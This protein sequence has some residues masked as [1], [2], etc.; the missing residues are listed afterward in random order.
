MCAVL[1]GISLPLALPGSFI[2]SWPSLASDFP[3]LLLCYAVFLCYAVS[4]SAV[5]RGISFPP[6][7]SGSFF[8]SWPSLASDSTSSVSMLLLLFNFALC[9]PLLRVFFCLFVCAAS[10]SRVSISHGSF[11]PPYFPDGLVLLV[12]ELMALCYP[13]SLSLSFFFA[14]YS[15]FA[16]ALLSSFDFWRTCFRRSAQFTFAFASNIIFGC[17][18]VLCLL[19]CI[20]R[21]SPLRS[22][23]IHL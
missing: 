7:L 23:S 17:L 12:L 1:C 6:A 8:S 20:T 10:P 5:L 3:F 13:L 4:M 2:S 22:C 21:L 15:I 16:C 19:T 11:S 14:G 18:Y 9:S